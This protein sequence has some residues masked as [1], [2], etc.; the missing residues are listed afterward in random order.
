MPAGMRTGAGT[1][2]AARAHT[3]KRNAMLAQT[4]AVASGGGLQ[5]GF[6]LWCGHILARTADGTG[7]MVV[8]RLEGLCQANIR[9]PAAHM[10]GGNANTLEHL[11]CPVDASA[12]TAWRSGLG[13]SCG[14]CGG[15]PLGDMGPLKWLVGLLQYTQD[16]QAR[17]GNAIAMV[18]QMLGDGGG[19]DCHTGFIVAHG[20]FCCN[21]RQFCNI[22]AK[23]SRGEYNLPI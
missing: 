13:A 5:G 7:N 2:L 4:I 3:T 1:M 18:A 17:C 11:Q 21:N 15:G 19:S 22:F 8:V 12:I 9:R 20:P 23:G 6:E 16:C 14:R 10:H